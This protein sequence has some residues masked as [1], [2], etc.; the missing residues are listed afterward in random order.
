M[1]DNGGLHPET[2]RVLVDVVVVAVT[3]LVLVAV[4]VVNTTD[5]MLKAL[6]SKLA[7]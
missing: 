4:E 6:L 1:N 7:S 3:T 5:G 2:T